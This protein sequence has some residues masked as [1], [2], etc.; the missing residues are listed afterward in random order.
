M[1]FNGGAGVA[2]GAKSAFIV[3]FNPKFIELST[4]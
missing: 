4:I 3:P 1:D 2:N